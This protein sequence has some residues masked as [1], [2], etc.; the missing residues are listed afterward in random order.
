MAL[1]ANS[2]KPISILTAH[3]ALDPFLPPPYTAHQK[4]SFFILYFSCFLRE[5]P[6]ARRGFYR[7]RGTRS[8]P[9]HGRHGPR[10]RP[11]T[12][13]HSRDCIRGEFPR[14]RGS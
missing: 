12:G 6:Y 14:R 10:C 4:F 5:V 9:H 7:N 13:P 11:R 2:V 1:N 3:P 8:A